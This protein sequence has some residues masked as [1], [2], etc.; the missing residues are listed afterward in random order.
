[1]KVLLYSHTFYPSIGGIETVSM[2]LANGFA[3]N[4]IT[5]KVITKTPGAGD[6]KL[7][8]EVF[9]NPNRRR[10]IDLVK[11]A[12]V[13]LF[14][15]ASLALQPWILFFRK[16]FVWIHTGYQVSC[17]DGLG[18]VNG[19]R[20]PLDPWR[21]FLFHKNLKGWNW[22]LVAVAKL[23]IRR[24]VAK[25]FVAKNIAITEWMFKVQALPRQVCIYNPFP[26]NEIDNSIKEHDYDFL[27][28]GRIVSE[29]GVLTLLRAFSKVLL[30][31]NQ[32]HRLLIIGDGD[33]RKSMEAAAQEL[34]I[35]NFVTFTGNQTGDDLLSWLS[36]G[37][38]GVIPSEWYE[39]MG[40]VALEL[41]SLGKNLIVS[42]K[43]GL[44]ECVGNAALTFPNGDHEA[45]A[46]CMCR[47]LED[48]PL[49]EAQL[50]EAK[51]RI[52]HFNPSVSVLKYVSL[53]KKIA[54]SN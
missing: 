23:L 34:E 10:Q 52:K 36:K 44:K 4:A 21:S 42:E 54:N 6:R 2:A 46:E 9:R 13:V 39:A 37:K 16:P 17:I 26:I 14:N 8:F 29:K 49:R 48:V 51:E 50:L 47:L 38:I 25:H 32:C 19:R 24:T 18:W 31:R 20:A 3:N 53:L 30:M 7:G 27:Y 43:G 41:M 33:W 28:L 15:G 12:D 1:M 11:W 22:G 40:G 35:S 5:F 45:L